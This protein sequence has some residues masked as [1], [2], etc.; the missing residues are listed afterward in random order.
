MNRA[1]QLRVARP[2]GCALSK[3]SSET[4]PTISVVQKPFSHACIRYMYALQANNPTKLT[5]D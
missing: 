3:Y 5:D 4:I 2:V 1:C